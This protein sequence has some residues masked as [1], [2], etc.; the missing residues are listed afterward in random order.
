M[1]KSKGDVF[2]V[3]RDGHGDT[4]YLEMYY[5]QRKNLLEQFAIGIRMTY[6]DILYVAFI[7]LLL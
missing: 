7:V 3:W 6:I 2:H 1:I 4:D 5:P